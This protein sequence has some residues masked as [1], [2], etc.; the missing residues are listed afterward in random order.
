[1]GSTLKGGI[2]YWQAALGFLGDYDLVFDRGD[3]SIAVRV[4]VRPKSYSSFVVQP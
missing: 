1:V 4:K 3:S 2:F